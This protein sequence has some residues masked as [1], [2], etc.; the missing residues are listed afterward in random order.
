[1]DI[2]EELKAIISNSRD[3]DDLVADIENQKFEL[4][5]KSH[6]LKTISFANKIENFVKNDVFVEKSIGFI[7]LEYLYAD[8]SAGQIT[9]DLLTKDGQYIVINAHDHSLVKEALS[10]IIGF[11]DEFVNNDFAGDSYKLELKNGVGQEIMD[12]FL[13]D[14][15]KKIYDYSKMQL[16]LS[17]N[18]GNH[19]KLKM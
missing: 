12:L 16:E 19:K 10:H 4:L 18:A 6:L 13:S 15:L 9:F 11:N 14:E 7:E 17:E 2:K 3:T 5:K 1:V 8:L